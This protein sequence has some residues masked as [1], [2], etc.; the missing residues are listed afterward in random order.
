MLRIC[1]V[2]YVASDRDPISYNFLSTVALDIAGFT[3][4]TW[5]RQYEKVSDASR[6]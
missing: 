2:R 6:V 5:Y 3:T 4:L 1:G